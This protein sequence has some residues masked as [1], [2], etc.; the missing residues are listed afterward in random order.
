M[1]QDLTGHHQH[2]QRK[3]ASFV[4]VGLPAIGN[5]QLLIAQHW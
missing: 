3:E 5:M 1:L 2:Y 4:Y